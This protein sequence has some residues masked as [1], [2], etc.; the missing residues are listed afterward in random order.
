LLSNGEKSKNYFAKENEI[1]IIQIKNG[2]KHSEIQNVNS[3]HSKKKAN[4]RRYRSGNTKHLYNYLILAIF[5]QM[6]KNTSASEKSEILF[7]ILKDVKDPLTYEGLS[8]K[9][10]PEFVYE[11]I[12]DEDSNKE[13]SPNSIKDNRSTSDYLSF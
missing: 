9:R 3:L 6:H 8:N 7:E 2:M 5:E 1:P 13:A 4:F 11:N 12:L 10:Y